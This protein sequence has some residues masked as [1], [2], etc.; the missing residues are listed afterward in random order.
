MAEAAAVKLDLNS[1]G[2]ARREKSARR[3]VSQKNLLDFGRASG[4]PWA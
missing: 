4:L 2:N 3:R 1:S